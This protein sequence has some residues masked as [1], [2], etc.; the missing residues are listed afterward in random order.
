VNQA[1]IG[2]LDFSTQEGVHCNDQKKYVANC[3]I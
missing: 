2:I 1:N 3:P